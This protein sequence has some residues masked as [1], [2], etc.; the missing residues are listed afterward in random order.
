MLQNGTIVEFLEA[1]LNAMGEKHNITFKLYADAAM[2]DRKATVLGL[3]RVVGD[4]NTPIENFTARTYKYALSFSVKDHLL[5]EKIA[6]F[7]RI[8]ADVISELNGK[9]FMLDN[10]EAVFNFDIPQTGDIKMEGSAY[11]SNVPSRLNFSVLYTLNAVTTAKKVWMLDDKIIPYLEESVD[12]EIEGST[13]PIYG[14]HTAKSLTNKQTKFY[15]FRL[16]YDDSDLCR[17]LQADIL[18]SEID[19]TY[20]L[21]YYD[22]IS[23][24]EDKPFETCVALFRTVGNQATRPSVSTFTVIFTDADDGADDSVIYEMALID[25]PFDSGSVN[26]RW[27]ENTAAQRAWYDEKIQNGTP[28]A[29]IKAPNLNSLTITQQVYIKPQNCNLGLNDLLTKNYAVI[30]V[31]GQNESDTLYYYYYVVSASVGAYNQILVN[32]QMDT[33]QTYYFNESLEIP[34]C[35]IERAH[36]NRWVDNGDGTV[37]FDNTI[38]SKLFEREP[39]NNLSKRNASRTKIKF[40]PDKTQGSKFNEWLNDN[41]SCWV[42]VYLK[43]R[44]YNVYSGSA[45]QVD[46]GEN[47]SSVK[48]SDGSPTIGNPNSSLN[49]PYCCFCYPVFYKNATQIKI[50]LLDGKEL[51]IKAEAFWD[52]LKT[53]EIPKD[54]KD[55]SVFIDGGTANI[56]QIKLSSLPPFTPNTYSEGKEANKYEINEN[57]LTLHTSF[58]GSGNWFG[59]IGFL[60]TTSQ[61]GVIYLPYQYVDVPMPTDKIE[62]PQCVFNKNDIINADKKNKK[63]NPKLF[64]QDYYEVKLTNDIDEFVYDYQKLGDQSPS[65]LYTEPLTADIT[66]FYLRY[67]SETND[68]IYNANLSQNFTGLV[69]SIDLS[70]PYSINQLDEFFANNKNFFVQRKNKFDVM[71]QELAQNTL[72]G[73]SQALLSG[74][75]GSLLNTGA[76]LL[77]GIRNIKAQSIESELSLDNMKNAP[78][79]VQNANGNAFLIHAI[80]GCAFYVE[81]YSALENELE[82][83]NDYMHEYG[84][85]F[86]RLENIREYDHIRHYFNYIQADIDAIY[87]VSMSNDARNDLRRRFSQGI[88]FWNSDEIQY[89]WENYENWLEEVG[90]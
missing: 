59:K 28:Y 40:L 70:L 78:E 63:F 58:N 80:N 62:L 73:L 16:P 41:I 85:S 2:G 34:P 18:K 39:I 13:N 75:G 54:E 9:S 72:L 71:G 17:M 50:H 66:R 38:N 88:R 14:A 51:H 43:K 36:L 5:G 25:N 26:V 52:W 48:I 47:L 44:E 79:Q 22:G 53:N 33:V 21:K 1:R 23:F 81:T 46:Y 57:T 61:E 77:S 56:L 83:A 19:K 74:S 64:N 31:S 30:K 12:L 35:L 10:G 4:D 60:Q 6:V 87:G 49:M 84:F 82:I 68:T 86:N 42:Y 15:K 29:R 24:T 89:E 90:S 32:L 67:N 69:G 7:N 3:L 8:V 27:F 65:F 55:M 45:V 37:S 11:A 20:K 76:S